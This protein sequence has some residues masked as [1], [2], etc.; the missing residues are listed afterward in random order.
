MICNKISYLSK[1]KLSLCGQPQ[2]FGWMR[3]CPDTLMA[4]NLLF[5]VLWLGK[6]FLA[7]AHTYAIAAGWSAIERWDCCASQELCQHFK[8]M[9]CAIL[10]SLVDPW[11]NSVHTIP[12][13]RKVRAWSEWAFTSLHLKT[14]TKKQLL[15]CSILSMMCN[16]SICAHHSRTS[17]AASQ[18][19]IAH[20]LC[21]KVA[22]P[23]W[24]DYQVRLMESKMAL[25]HLQ[26]GAHC[27]RALVTCLQGG[28]DAPRGRC[29]CLQQ[30]ACI[31]YSQDP[32]EGISKQ[33][34]INTS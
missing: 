32:L 23:A 25:A 27:N 10:L 2:G 9:R 29:V 33:L 8:A 6:H 34:R 16:W 24:H 11:F 1:F 22:T 28:Q 12:S 14:R 3:N 26:A 19:C 15:L 7:T 18:S 30:L 21:S 31:W 20:N 5:E 13:H 17:S 4:H